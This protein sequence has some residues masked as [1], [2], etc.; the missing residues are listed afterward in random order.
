MQHIVRSNKY[1]KVFAQ[2]V[3]LGLLAVFTLIVSGL[4]AS[5]AHAHGITMSPHSHYLMVLE[6]GTGHNWENKGAFGTFKAC[7]QAA[8]TRL[9]LP[10]EIFTCVPA[11]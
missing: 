10:R 5:K 2:V 6:K 1:M 11:W 3:L 9:K 7:E 8:V 4:V